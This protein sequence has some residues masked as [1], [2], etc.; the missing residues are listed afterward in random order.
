MM[1][2]LLRVTLEYL[3]S[4]EK[5]LAFAAH[6]SW[7]LKSTRRGPIIAGRAIVEVVLMRRCGLCP[8]VSV[9]FVL[10]CI[11]IGKP[12]LILLSLQVKVNWKP[13]L[14]VLLMREFFF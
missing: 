1:N 4:G 7:S 9:K 12:F 11:F 14:V 13:P 8:L 2:L 3:Y 10:C 6:H 5:P